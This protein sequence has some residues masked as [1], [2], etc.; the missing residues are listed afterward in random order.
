MSNLSDLCLLHRVKKESPAHQALRYLGVEEVP[1]PN[2]LFPAGV[3]EVLH[4][5]SSVGI[6]FGHVLA[7]GQAT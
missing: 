2:R 1:L 4:A 6:I 7:P 3:V 5:M